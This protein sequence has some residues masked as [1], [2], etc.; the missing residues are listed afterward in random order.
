MLPLKGKMKPWLRNIVPAYRDWWSRKQQS[1]P[2]FLP[3]KSH[4]RR[5]L[6]D[7]NPWGHKELNTTERQSVQVLREMQLPS[8]SWQF[9]GPSLELKGRGWAHGP[10][11][12]TVLLCY[13]II[14]WFLGMSNTWSLQHIFFGKGDFLNEVTFIKS[15]LIKPFLKVNAKCCA[16]SDWIS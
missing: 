5:S 6:E 11:C 15:D 3:G 1:T 16:C 9:G 2:V 13:S 7:C 14:L 10:L 4:G 8:S 12:V